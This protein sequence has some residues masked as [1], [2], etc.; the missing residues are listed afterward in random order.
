MPDLG[1]P[2]H[3]PAAAPCCAPAARPDAAVVV[4]GLTLRYGRVPVFRDVHL[5]LGRGRVTA[6]VGPSGAGKTSLLLCLNR[7]I[8]TIP[9]A[10]IDGRIQVGG[11]DILGK[12]DVAALRRDV[13]LVFQR[14]NPFP[15]SIARNLEIPLREHRRLTRAELRAEIERAL[16][17]VGLWDEVK[18]RLDQ[19]ALQLSGGQKQRLCIARALV[20][21]PHVLLMDEP[22]SALDRMASARIEALIRELRGSYT[23]LLVTHNM[24]QARRVADDVAVFW[25]EDG[26]GT[27]I[28]CGDAEQI[29]E[30]PCCE[31]TAEY[32]REAFLT[33]AATVPACD[34]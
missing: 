23:I 5:S 16:V 31:A 3:P 27:I 14:P 9:E 4:D 25:P 18:D 2:E 29:F 22:C 8:D 33:V 21:R 10:N 30:R 28:E 11:R 26:V 17:A 24:A 13:G 7:L 12:I 34:T 19:S 15:L 6:L 1:T 20:L 32:L